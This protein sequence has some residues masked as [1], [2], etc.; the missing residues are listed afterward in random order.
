MSEIILKQRDDIHLARKIWHISTGLIGLLIFNFFNLDQR[1]V[2]IG[3][4]IVSL[5]GFI[6]ELL[7]LQSA[8]LNEI[9]LKTMGKVMRKSEASKVSGLP[10]YA[11]GVGISF[12]L[13]ERDIAFLSVLF[14]VFSDPVSSL[15]GIIFGTQK[16][17]EGKS[18]QGSV[19]GLI[20]CYLITLNYGL[21]QG[22][23]GE[24]L[25]IF[26]VLSGIIGMIS[27]LSSRYIDD[28][29]AIPV[30]SGLGLS[31]LNAFTPLF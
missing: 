19:A 3:L 30:F 18:L 14:L 21:A 28:N 9:V 1:N 10:F 24:D 6:F 15:V 5:V 26:S 23:E 22:I 16:L 8:A 12:F 2:G 31:L 17:V 20:T 13:F 29:L 4:M 11:L 27:E 25:F 7:R